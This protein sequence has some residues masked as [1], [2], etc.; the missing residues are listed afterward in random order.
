MDDELRNQAHEAPAGDLVA[1]DA[2][3]ARLR[4]ADPAASFDVRDLDLEALRAAVDTRRSSGVGDELAARRARRFSGWPVRTAAAVALA[5]AVGGGGGYALGATGGGDAGSADLT[6]ADGSAAGAATEAPITL[7]VPGL[8]MGGAEESAGASADRAAFWGGWYGR[9]VFTGQGL[10][11][12]R[13]TGRAWA[14]DATAVSADAAK[15]A[16]EVLGVSGEPR[17]DYGAWVIGPAD[18]Q[19]ATVS[20]SADGV[21]TLSYWDPTMDV[22]WCGPGDAASGG[23]SEV[24]IATEPGAATDAVAPQVCEER[25]L[26][27]APVG[28]AAADVLREHMTALGVDTAPFEFVVEDSGDPKYAFVTAYHVVDGVRTGLT[29]SAS[30]TAAGVSSLYG[31]TGTLVDLGEYDVVSP[32]EA[33]ERLNDPRFGAGAVGPMVR[34][35][36]DTGMEM[37]VEDE[38]DAVPPTPAAP[39]AAFAW[40]VQFVTI[41]GARL[42]VA[43]V[44][45]EGGATSLAPAYELTAADGSVWSVIAVAE[46]HLR[47]TAD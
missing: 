20:L 26:G 5:L 37:A 16:A 45:G 21:G 33:V 1:E 3:V 44:N 39:G 29:W 25:D 27:P 23:D 41:T 36:V 10:S 42:G 12:D 13:A 17:L 14:V 28:D 8:D 2:A 19:G 15:A 30:L 6:A 38:P 35:A 7:A 18:A 31:F 32:A 9:T 24:G 40:P 46:D 4:A 34:G 11:T 22:W 43:V 47:F